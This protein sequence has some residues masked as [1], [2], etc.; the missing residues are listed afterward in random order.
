MGYEVNFTPPYEVNFT[1]P[2]E[3]NF[4]PPL[5]LVVNFIGYEVFVLLML[6]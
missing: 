6:L 3:V 4:T 5:Y 2:Y 1:P